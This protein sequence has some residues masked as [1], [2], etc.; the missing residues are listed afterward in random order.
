MEI[1]QLSL[2]RPQ[3]RLRNESTMIKLCTNFG[4]ETAGNVLINLSH[5]ILLL[6]V[7][8]RKEPYYAN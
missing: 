8:Q 6:K 5:L 3:T 7:Q 4:P 1:H 2:E